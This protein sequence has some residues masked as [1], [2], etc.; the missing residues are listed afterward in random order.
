MGGVFGFLTAV[1]L[2]FAIVYI[3]LT[4]YARWS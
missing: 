4:V 1:I 3:E 2:W